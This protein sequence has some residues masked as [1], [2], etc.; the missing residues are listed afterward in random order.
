MRG[1]GR[2]R[3]A[4]RKAMRWW[5]WWLGG[6]L[7]VLTDFLSP[8]LVS[9]LRFLL[10]GDIDLYLID[11][12]DLARTWE[13]SFFKRADGFTSLPAAKEGRTKNLERETHGRGRGRAP[14]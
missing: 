12:F 4:K 1:V 14:Y 13:G 5:L 11:L 10:G 9:I 7:Y 2:R 8:F 6:I 3:R